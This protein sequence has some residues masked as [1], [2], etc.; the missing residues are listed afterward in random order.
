MNWLYVFSDFAGF[1]FPA[2][3]I[4]QCSLIN[5]IAW[6]PYMQT[7]KLG[8]PWKRVNC[9]ENLI[10]QA[11]QWWGWDICF[12]LSGGTAASQNYGNEEGDDIWN[13]GVF[14]RPDGV[15]SPAALR[16]MKTNNDQ[17]LRVLH[18]S[19]LICIGILLIHGNRIYFPG[20]QRPRHIIKH[21]PTFSIHSFI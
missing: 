10:L 12:V 15:A 20:V 4:L 3:I 8:A 21:P 18:C 1:M 5:P 2:C 6:R 17:S 13:V 16:W 19:Y 14:K 9:L 7:A 11:L